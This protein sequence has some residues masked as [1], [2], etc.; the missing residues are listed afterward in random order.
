MGRKGKEC[1]EVWA[2]TVMGCGHSGFEYPN[3]FLF[4]CSGAE[5]ART[6]H[7]YSFLSFCTGSGVETFSFQIQ[8]IPLPI[9]ISFN[10]V[11]TS[12]TRTPLQ[13]SWYLYNTVS[14]GGGC[15]TTGTL[16]TLHTARRQF[17]LSYELSLSLSLSLS[18]CLIVP[19]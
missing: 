10:T 6:H 4:F 2:K 1:E 17:A 19:M 12:H 18:I 8:V 13:S 3:C 5:R 14:C 15:Y 9:Y 11:I 16:Q 7:H